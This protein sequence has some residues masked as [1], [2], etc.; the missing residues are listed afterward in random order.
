MW[1]LSRSGLESVSP[2]LAGGFFTTEPP[3]KLSNISFIWRE[4]GRN[5]AGKL[6]PLGVVHIDVP[7]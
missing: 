6:V 3:G 4:S 1:D 5:G 2:A 7:L